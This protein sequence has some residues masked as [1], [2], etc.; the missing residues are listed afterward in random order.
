MIF[1]ISVLKFRMGCSQKHIWIIRCISEV[2]QNGQLTRTTNQRRD[3]ESD[4]LMELHYDIQ[5]C[6]MQ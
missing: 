5:Y 1:K 3:R 2:K 6:R 4:R